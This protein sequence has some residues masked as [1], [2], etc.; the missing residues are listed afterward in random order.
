MKDFDA[1][2]M[3]KIEI[4]AKIIELRKEAIKLQAQS[5]TGSASK[6]PMQIMNVKKNIARL[7]TALREKE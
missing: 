5:A 2:K 1:N 4:E 7:A 6:N 3:S